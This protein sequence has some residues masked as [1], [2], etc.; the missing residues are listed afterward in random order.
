[1]HLL[2]AGDVGGEG[3]DAPVGR[4]RQLPRR[5]L[6]ISLGS[7]DDRHIDAFARQFP[8]NG[9]ANAPATARHNRMLAL[10]SEVHGS[11]PL[12]A[13]KFMASRLIVLCEEAWRKGV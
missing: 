5:C 3:Q 6:E 9:L 7:R 4:G 12:A 11:L 1:F 13:R 8:R 10:Q 2:F